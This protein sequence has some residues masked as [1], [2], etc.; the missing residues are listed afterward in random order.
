MG[1]TREGDIPRGGG[2]LSGDPGNQS[3][4]PGHGMSFP[5]E[6]KKATMNTISFLLPT[7]S[8]K[9]NTS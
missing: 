4:I 3:S 2:T 9:M 7:T 6:T 8:R 5:Q 1:E